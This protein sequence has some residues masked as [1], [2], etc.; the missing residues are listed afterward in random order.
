MKNILTTTLLITTLM[1]TSGCSLK[2]PFHKEKA[3]EGT[4]TVYIYRASKLGVDDNK[5]KIYVDGKY[6]HRQ[7]KTNEYFP[8][9]IREGDV[10]ISAISNGIIEHELTMDLDNEKDYFIRITPIEGDDFT[11]KAVQ[12][13]QALTQIAKTGLSGSM[14]E[15]D[16]KES[17]L[18]EKKDTEVASPLAPSD[19]IT[20]LYEM[21]ERGIIT[22][23]EFKSLKAK[24]IAK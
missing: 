7:L 10:T 6:S 12:E 24:V 18:V 16:P 22:E 3:I 13:P 1:F 19:E 9:H 5:Y 2:Q 23:A 15:E 20:K 8:F 11:L 14:F 21:K 4:A 17:K